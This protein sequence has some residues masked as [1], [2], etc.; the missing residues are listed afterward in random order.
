MTPAAG[1]SPR[2]Q[3]VVVALVVVAGFAAID[4][5]FS[6]TAGPRVAG[7][8]VVDIRSPD[9]LAAKLEYLRT[10][11]GYKCALLGDSLIVGQSMRDHGDADWRAH[12]LNVL[13]DQRLR[14]RVP[15]RP[16]LVMNLGSNGAVPADL[17]E[18][19]RIIEPLAPD[20]IVADIGLRSFSGDF[21]GPDR[22]TQP[23]LAD[24]PTP[25]PDRPVVAA[26]PNRH[27]VDRAIAD[28]LAAHWALYRTR[29]LQQ[30]LAF[31]GSP[32]DAVARWRDA[33]ARREP[34]RPAEDVDTQV[35]LLFKARSRYAGIDLGPGGEQRQAF[36]RLLRRWAAGRARAVLFYAAENP[37]V[38]DELLPP[39][40]YAELRRELLDLIRPA[41]S[42]RLG[43]H[44]GATDVP[45]SRYLDH[46]HV[47]AGGYRMLA[48][49]LWPT[50][51][52]VMSAK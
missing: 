11:D 22:M 16:V 38:R 24:F 4:V 43:F 30:G 3:F 27:P 42:S 49:D 23:W 17:E 12:T 44:P 28:G 19:A 45:A 41:I 32:R 47:D 34:A 39:E 20:L 8:E 26:D 33:H 18:L 35:E 2:V 46:V 13:L 37:D 36:E 1:P 21:R 48:D 15:G 40:R 7:T 29:D 25:A 9:A 31:D 10:F 14:E 50:I 5:V 52:Q 6:R 51:E